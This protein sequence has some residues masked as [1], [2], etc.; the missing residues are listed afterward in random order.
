LLALSLAAL[1]SVPAAHAS[2]EV[3]TEAPDFTLQALDDSLHT[4]SDQRG[5]VVLLAIIGYG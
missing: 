5:K 4:L 2:G 3:G 1:G